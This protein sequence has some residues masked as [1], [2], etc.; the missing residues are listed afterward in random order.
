M[1]G[2]RLLARN[3]LI[4]LFG[5]LTP[6]LAAYFAIPRLVR[7]MGTESFGVL[8]LTWSFIGYFSLF[9][10]GLGRALTKLVSEKLGAGLDKEIPGLVRTSL[11]LML[12]PG[13]I[14]MLLLF[15]F[16]RKAAVQWLQIPGDLES[17]VTSVLHLLALCIPII[18]TTAGLQGLL[19][20]KQRFDLINAVRIPLGFLT[21]LGPLAAFAVFHSLFAVIATLVACR[22]I[23]WA[24]ILI[25]CWKVTPFMSGVVSIKLVQV[26]SLIRFG[27]WMTVSNIISPMMVNLDRWLIGAVAS[28][29]AVAYYA[30]PF[31]IVNKLFNVPSAL[32]KVLFPAFSASYDVDRHRTETMFV[33]GT[34]H[35]LLLLFPLVLLIVGAAREILNWWL[36][37]DFAQNSTLVLQLLAIGVLISSL[38]LV[39]FSLVQGAGRPNFTAKL[40]LIELPIYA[41]TVWGLVHRFGIVGAAFAWLLR[42][43]IDGL[44]L[45]HKAWSL[46]ATAR[47]KKV[48]TLLSMGCALGVLSCLVLIPNLYHRLIL[49]VA[50][51]V[52]FSWVAWRHLIDQEEKSFILVNV[53]TKALQVAAGIRSS[54]AAILGG[55]SRF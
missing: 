51:L 33:K 48:Q 38:S 46:L 34:K 3:A 43:L 19:E 4:N 37:V 50:L 18:I 14:A 44:I 27:G 25:V 12:V 13:L 28:M 47:I 10:L 22:L 7:G 53:R 6:L 5:Q 41:L 9:D 1:T 8:A 29:N 55:S 17:E 2:G 49:M 11:F 23:G 30:T 26:G 54:W 32:I 52:A 45:F 24:A 35:I 16:A 40:H 21:Y 31:E 42:V 39:P 36:G 15:A 20:A